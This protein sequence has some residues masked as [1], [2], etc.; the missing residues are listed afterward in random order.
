MTVCV[1]LCED[2][3]TPWICGTQL[4]D[5]ILQRELVATEFSVLLVELLGLTDA[6]GVLMSFRS[7][8]LYVDDSLVASYTK[9][10]FPN[11]WQ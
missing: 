9:L 5:T 2:S 6:R 1:Y 4:G 10:C 8:R 3:L 11:L 7:C